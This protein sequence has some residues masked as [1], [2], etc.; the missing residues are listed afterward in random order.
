M[1][2][3]FNLRFTVRPYGGITLQNIFAKEIMELDF[4]LYRVYPH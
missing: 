2:I 1:K 3:I 4:N